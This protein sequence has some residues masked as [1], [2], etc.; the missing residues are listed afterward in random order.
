[1]THVFGLFLFGVTLGVQEV[2]EEEQL[3][4]DKEDKQ[5][6]ADDQP[7]GFAHSHAAESIIIQV[8]NTR[9]ESLLIVIT[10]THGERHLKVKQLTKL[11]T[12][13]KFANNWSKFL[14]KPQ[15]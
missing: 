5:L 4:D 11:V 14:L 7:Q 1:M 2:G 6:D 12:K 9:P 10:V 15:K 8:K 13:F 3:D